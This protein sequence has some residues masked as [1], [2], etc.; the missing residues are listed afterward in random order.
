MLG[1]ASGTLETVR[2]HLLDIQEPAFPQFGGCTATRHVL[3]HARRLRAQ[4]DVPE[5][6]VRRKWGLLLLVMELDR[7]ERNRM[8]WR[9]SGDPG[10]VDSV[11]PDLLSLKAWPAQRLSVPKKVNL[12]V[13][14]QSSMGA[15]TAYKD[16]KVVEGSPPGPCPQCLPSG[17]VCRGSWV[18][19]S[20]APVAPGVC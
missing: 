17:L 14:S 19:G 15:Q 10:Q 11:H 3:D 18:E 9:S 7:P 5:P 1:R 4:G 16:R 6:S 20:E 12:S 2:S 8:T 13:D